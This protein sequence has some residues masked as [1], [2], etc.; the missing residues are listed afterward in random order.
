[1][2]LKNNETR[3]TDD[4]KSWFRL[5]KK[6]LFFLSSSNTN[7]QFHSR[8]FWESF[9]MLFHHHR[10]RLRSRDRPR[11]GSLRD[12]LYKIWKSK[13][14]LLFFI[15]NFYTFR[16]SWLESGRG[17]AY[18]HSSYPLLIL[19]T[20]ALPVR[21]DLSLI[22]SHLP[23]VGLTVFHWWVRIF[24]SCKIWNLFNLFNSVIIFTILRSGVQV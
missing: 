15:Y 4:S 19:C 24:S 5:W 17:R 14:F 23:S 8:D 9:R 13:S 1:M 16:P 2:W 21:V 6:C 10:G 22:W 7:V 3:N 18:F 12:A 20:V 11:H